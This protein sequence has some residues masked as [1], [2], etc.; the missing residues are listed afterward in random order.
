MSHTFP[1]TLL[2]AEYVGLD[3][4]LLQSQVRFWDVVR[5]CHMVISAPSFRY[6]S[7]LPGTSPFLGRSASDD[8]FFRDLIWRDI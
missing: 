3:E 1:E 7:P 2:F 8:Y 4:N 5:E 6:L